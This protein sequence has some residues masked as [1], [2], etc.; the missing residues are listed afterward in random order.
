MDAHATIFDAWKTL[1]AGIT[2]DNGYTTNIGST[3]FVF[4][5]YKTEPLNDAEL[6]CHNVM[7][8]VQST[9]LG[10]GESDCTMTLIVEAFPASAADVVTPMQNMV[11]DLRNLI[12]ANRSASGLWYHAAQNGD[13]GSLETT[14]AGR[15]IGGVGITIDII[16]ATRTTI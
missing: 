12:A 6:P 16:Y 5:D 2:T 3:Q 14:V 7:H 13:I 4:R 8:S 15:V 1:L 11:Q 10:N 9:D